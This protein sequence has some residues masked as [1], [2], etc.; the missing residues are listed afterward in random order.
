MDPN[1]VHSLLMDRWSTLDARVDRVYDHLS[2]MSQVQG[3]TLESLRETRDR[4]ETLESQGAKVSNL[5]TYLSLGAMAA[6]GLLVTGLVLSTGSNKEAEAYKT[7]LRL[8][9]ANQAYNECV[10]Q[11][12]AV[13][14]SQ[15]AWGIWSSEVPKF[16]ECQKPEGK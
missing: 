8:N 13:E 2:T 5:E 16:R 15:A 11:P 4:L 1:Q 6:A 7:S 3:G 10:R 12:V 9:L 14:R